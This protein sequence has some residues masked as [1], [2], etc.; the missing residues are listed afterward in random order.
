MFLNKKKINIS[1]KDRVQLP[2]GYF[3]T[4]TGLL[5]RHVLEK[6]RNTYDDSETNK[7]FRS[8]WN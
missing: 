6:N 7:L 4:P 5:Q 2:E 8:R 1:H 3:R